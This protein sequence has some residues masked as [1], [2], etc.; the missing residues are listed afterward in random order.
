MILLGGSYDTSRGSYTLQDGFTQP[1]KIITLFY[2]KFFLWL[3]LLPRLTLEFFKKF[4]GKFPS[5]TCWN[6]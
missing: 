2:H 3:P 5:L 6:Y 4:L 1:V